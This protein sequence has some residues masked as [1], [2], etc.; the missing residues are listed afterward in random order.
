MAVA[1]VAFALPAAASAKRVRVFA[2]GPKLDVAWL[3]SRATYHDKMFALF[4]RRLRGPGTPL[5]QRGA[6]DAASHLRGGGR[7]LVAWPEDVGLFAALVGQRAEA[8]RGSGSLEGSIAA[9]IATHGPQM[10]YYASRY[11]E[12]AARVP[13]VRL[14]ALALTDTFGRVA[15]ETFAEMAD[16][17]DVYLEVGA[18][19][20]ER[21]QVVC[22]DRE[23]FNSAR[24]PRLPGGVR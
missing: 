17:Y 22:L 16:R 15:V 10:S 3:E 9:L 14:L 19:L 7:D 4:D 5:V 1:A 21:H 6:D 2:M 23:A 8:A 12:T 24:P 18:P 20:T 11:P 13:Q